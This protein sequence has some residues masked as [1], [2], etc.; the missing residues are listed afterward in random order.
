MISA[1]QAFLFAATG[2][3]AW[4]LTELVGRPIL[5]FLELRRE[6]REQ[7][8]R[9]GNVPIVKDILLMA[10]DGIVGRVPDLSDR[11][12]EGA[13]ECFR[14]LGAR[15]H[16]FETEFFA[17]W[18]ATNVLLFRPKIAAEGLIGLSNSYGS[19]ERAAHRSAVERALRIGDGG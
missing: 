5:R 17:A 16:A 14:N 13:K 19:P 4:F 18:I 6:V 12:L 7:M 15:M 1:V 3:A 11:R 2:I 8:V 9:F 10:D